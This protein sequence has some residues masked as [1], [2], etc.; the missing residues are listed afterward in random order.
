[1]HKAEAFFFFWNN[2]RTIF[3]FFF[4]RQRRAN[5]VFLMVGFFFPAAEKCKTSFLSTVQLQK[6]KDAAP[7]A[8]L[9]SALSVQE[10]KDKRTFPHLCQGMSGLCIPRLWLPFYLSHI[11]SSIHFPG[12]WWSHHPWECAKNHGCGT[13][14]WFSGG[15]GG[16]AGFLAGLDDP[17]G[18]FQAGFHVPVSGGQDSVC[19]PAVPGGAGSAGCEHKHQCCFD[20]D[21]FK[22]ICKSFQASKNTWIL[23]TTSWMHKM[24]VWFINSTPTV[25]TSTP[26]KIQLIHQCQYYQ[27]P[28]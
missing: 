19:A 18:L 13:W 5:L 14:A 8:H 2:S 12:H 25:S 26:L 28:P 21:I 6:P 24:K 20:K 3:F 10:L 17:E 16:G 9:T 7:P 22:W 1:M 4:L 11:L 27:C 23:L 15:Q